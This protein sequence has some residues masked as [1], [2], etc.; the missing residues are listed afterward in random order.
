MA[1]SAGSIRLVGNDAARRREVARVL[2]GAG[3]RVVVSSD[4]NDRGEPADLIVLLASTSDRI[5]DFLVHDSG[6]TSMLKLLDGAGS[7]SGAQ[8]LGF[9]PLP[10]G[11]AGL[12][13]AVR[14][15]MAGRDEAERAERE[16]ARQLLDV[17]QVGVFEIEA[18]RLTY[19]NDYLVEMSKYSKE[20]LLSMDLRKLVCSQDAERLLRTLSERFRG[21]VSARPSTY[22]FV[23]K[24]GDERE[25]EVVSQL[26]DTPRGARVEGTMRNVTGEARL[27]RL[28]RIVL[29]LGGVIL[30]EQDV[31][32]ILQLVLDTITE[33]SGFRRA[34]LALYDLAAS[35]PIDGAVTRILCSGLSR[36]DEAALAGRPTLTPEKRRLAFS[37]EYRLGAAYYVPHDR[38]PWARELGITGTVSIAG[39]HPDDMLFIPLRGSAGIVGTISVDDPADQSA[40]TLETIEPIARL[41]NFAALAIERAVKWDE[42]RNQNER[43]DGLSRFGYQV[44]HIQSVAELCE[45]TAR[46]ICDDLAYDYAALWLRDGDALMLEGVALRGAFPHDEIP[47]RG[48]RIPVTGDGLA[49]WAVRYM[50]PAVVDDALTD[51][52]YRPSRPSVRSMAAIPILGRKGV[53]GVMDVESQRLAAFRKQDLVALSSMASQLSVALAALGRRE[54]LSR[55]YTLGQRISESETVSEIVAGTLDFLVEQFGYPLASV[56]LDGRDGRLFAAGVRGAYAEQGLVEGWEVPAERGIV[57]WVARNKRHAVVHDVTTDP[58]YLEMLL[59]VRSEVAVPLLFAERLVGVLNVESPEP[60]SF[61]EE[62]RVVLEVIANHLAT[63][64]ANLESQ[65]SLREQAVRD[66]LTGLFNRH[67]F[68]SIIAPELARSDRYARP[69]T[70]MMVDVD[71]FRA[72][73]N[74]YGHLM[75]DEILREV[76]RVLLAYV[77]ESD[78]V[79]RYGGDEFLIFMPETGEQE[80]AAVA[81]RLREQVTALPRRKGVPDIALG[82]SV[83][84]YTRQP[85]QTWSLEAILEEA[86]R[87]L[88]A[89]KRARHIERHDGPD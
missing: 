86:D 16:S 61:D 35:D 8:R 47:A 36:E 12:V 38:A 17:A 69:F 64:L 43:L 26:V 88:Y 33:Y 42:L 2:A 71:N 54:V 51:A 25:V 41:A 80:A 73:N 84:I 63:A 57:S 81:S 83:G 40:P 59:G 65:A 44:A 78:R 11:E 34:V 9:L 32:R 70:V 37:D 5:A 82:L 76:S 85:R 7:E 31:H 28:H 75:G 55:I 49:R 56:F 79:I 30:G 77:R 67:Y 15:A 22:R 74:R 18:G 87:R 6:E 27:A 13:A 39:W 23:A 89:D 58:R 29:E 1:E 20:E 60:A 66:S 14:A 3:Y 46:R 10:D 45:A 68:N 62:D 53:R 72:V 19:A 50:E 4:C 24:D 52:R 21:V 48:V